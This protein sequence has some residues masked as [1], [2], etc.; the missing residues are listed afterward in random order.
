MTAPTSWPW[1]LLVAVLSGGELPELPAFTEVRR[2]AA[3]DEALAGDERRELL[4]DSTVSTAEAA[5]VLGVTRQRAHALR[6]ALHP[7]PGG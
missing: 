3:H 5:L 4:A 7:P 1:T 6:K 2:Y